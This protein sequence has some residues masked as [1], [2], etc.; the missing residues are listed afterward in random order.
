MS[1]SPQK[2]GFQR[3]TGGS[4]LAG[5][6]G[7]RDQRRQAGGVRG[8]GQTGFCGL[9]RSRPWSRNSHCCSR[10]SAGVSDL[11]SVD[12]RRLAASCGAAWRKDLNFRQVKG[13]RRMSMMI[14][15]APLSEQEMIA[16]AE[17]ALADISRDQGRRRQG[18]LRP[19]KRRRA[20]AGRAAGRRSRAAG[21]RARPRQD[22]AGRDA[23]H[24][25]RPRR[26]PH[27]VHARPDAVRHPRLRGD[28]AG[29]ARQALLPLH[30][31][32]DLRAAPDGRRDQPRQPAH[33]VGA[34]AVDAGVSRHGRRRRATT[35]PRPSTCWRRRTRWS[36]K[37]PIRC[38]KPSSTAS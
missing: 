30:P 4:A 38:P 16:E 13:L 17:K 24:R 37:A 36:R 11:S 21:R 5:A 27:P 20:H 7:A 6:G 35:C 29:R 3:S 32:P 31:R 19:G 10:L 18:H 26:P 14:K 15:E 9:V 1:R 28:G 22:Q 34:A 23:R 2:S 25:A 12:M 8:L 33:P